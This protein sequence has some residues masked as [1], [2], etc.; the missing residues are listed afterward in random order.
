MDLS[1]LSGVFASP[2]D[3]FRS[4]VDITIVSYLFYRLLGLIRGTRA[5]QLLKGLVLLLAFSAIASFLKLTMVNWLVEKLWILFAI[6]LPIVFQPELRR[7]LEQ[8][9]RGHFFPNH[10]TEWEVDEYEVVIEQIADAIS[11]LSRTKVGALIIL[12]RETDISEYMDSGV[13]MDSM[14][15]A[16]LLINIFV[17]NTPLHDGAVIIKEGRISKAAC[18]LPLS[19]NP[20]L[21]KRVGTR[22]RAGLG[23]AEVSDAVAVIVSEETGNISI[24]REGS[25]IK[26]SDAQNLKDAL[27][28]EFVV[29]EK[30]GDIFRRRWSADGE[31]SDQNRRP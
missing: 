25:L 5:E 21:D 14:V 6:V 28:K 27:T 7:L 16:G 1:F 31:D 13:E 10:D 26:C 30:W 11:T 17:P 9:G 12:T 29:Q 8:L 2:W 4:L 18:F 19:D 22:H 15:S 3:I 20:Y 24:A 23:I